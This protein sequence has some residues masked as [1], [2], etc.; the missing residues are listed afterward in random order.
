MK[1]MLGFIGHIFDGGWLIFFSV[2][3][4]LPPGSRED[5]IYGANSGNG[6]HYIRQVEPPQCLLTFLP[7]VHRRGDWGV[8]HSHWGS[9]AAAPGFEDSLSLLNWYW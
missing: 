5:D 6:F 8:Y 1:E 2:Y 9:Y 7:G 4:S 3:T